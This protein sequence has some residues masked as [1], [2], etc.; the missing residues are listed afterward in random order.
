[1]LDDIAAA[2]GSRVI[3][4]TVGEAN[5]VDAMLGHNAVIGGMAELLRVD[6]EGLDRY[7]DTI[8]TRV[9]HL[10][11]LVNDILDFSRLEAH[12]LTLAPE[13]EDLGQLVEEVAGPMAPLFE[14]AGLTLEIEAPSGVPTR[15][16]R[17]RM[18]QVLTNMLDN[19]RKFTPS[20]GVVT[21]SA[22]AEGGE[23]I[24]TLSDTGCGIAPEHQARIFEKF[25]QIDG[26]STRQ[27]GGLGLG[28]AICKHLVERHG[29]RITVESA[30]G[31]GSTFRVA[32]PLNASPDPT[33]KETP[34]AH[35]R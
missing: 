35:A 26:S 31:R 15:C 28:L 7:A 10:D 25:H 2:A 20:G 30:P 16:D 23:A 18:V 1:M 14:Q 29:G 33:P 11:G 9:R 21:L 27:H 13:D 34:L 17:L 22:R 3:R 4:T 32:L 12:E 5:V 8:E 6:P 24:L 19:A